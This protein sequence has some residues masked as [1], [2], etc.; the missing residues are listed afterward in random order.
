MRKTIKII[1]GIATL[2]PLLYM[3]F[4][5][6]TVLGS[7]LQTIQIPFTILIPL[8]L[9]TMIWLMGLMSFYLVNVLRNDTLNTDKKILWVVVLIMGN[10][11]AMPIY[12][13]MCLWQQNPSLDHSAVAERPSGREKEKENKLQ[14]E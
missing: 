12:W 11:V 2:L 4:F 10:M 9:L 3:I 13:Y 8:H 1:V 5:M 7:V 14:R 6:L